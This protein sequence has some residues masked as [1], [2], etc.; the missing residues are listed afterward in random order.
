MVPAIAVLELAKHATASMAAAPPRP[1]ILMLPFPAQGHVM[2]LMELSHRLADH[3]VEVYFVNTDLNHARIIKAMEG[4]GDQAGARP[5]AGIHMVS[6]PDGMAPDADRSNIG[7]LA[8]GLAAAM[9]GRLEELIRSKEIRWMVVD[10]PMVWA[11]ELAAVA[12][13]RV[14]LFPAFSAAVF[15]LMT[16][17]PKM[18]EDGILDEDGP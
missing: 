3:G 18:I 2:P 12:G 7:K 1:R 4:G 9:L 8:E 6:F 13:V 10:V 15:A 16:Y 11:L 17:A 14:A 5:P